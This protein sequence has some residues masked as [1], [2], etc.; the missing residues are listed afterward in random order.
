MG[1]VNRVI[2]SATRASGVRTTSVAVGVIEDH[3]IPA[4]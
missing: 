3:V 2:N 1:I 4:L